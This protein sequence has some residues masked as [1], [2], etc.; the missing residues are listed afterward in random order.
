TVGGPGRYLS[1][2]LLPIRRER[3]SLPFC[4][5]SPSE[6]CLRWV[7]LAGVVRHQRVLEGERVA[8][9]H[10]GGGRLELARACLGELEQRRRAD[11]IPRLRRRDREIG[12]LLLCEGDGELL[13]RRLETE[14]RA[15]NVER[16]GLPLV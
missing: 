14:V 12:R 15:T 3:W 6:Q 11:L 5:A 10:D 9:A 7:E 13:S 2:K 4:T 1:C 16:N 8:S